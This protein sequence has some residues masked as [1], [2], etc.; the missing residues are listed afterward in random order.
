MLET[1]QELFTSIAHVHAPIRSTRVRNKQSPWITSQIRKMIIDRDKLKTRAIITNYA[2]L[3]VSFK[4]MWNLVTNKVKEAKLRYYHSQI[5]KNVDD[6]RATCIWKTVNQ[7]SHRKHTSNSTTINTCTQ[8]PLT[9]GNDLR[10]QI[11]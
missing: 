11:F 2:N 6:S 7:L 1:W 4:K 3:W 10:M 9:Q 5:E 8:Q